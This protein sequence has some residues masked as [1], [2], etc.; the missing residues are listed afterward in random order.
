M[1]RVDKR[2]SI[3]FPNSV[4]IGIRENEYF[5]YVFSQLPCD[6]SKMSIL[7]FKY[8]KDL[9]VAAEELYFIDYNQEHKVI[10]AKDMFNICEKIKETEDIDIYY[11]PVS[12]NF[13]NIDE[14]HKFLK[15]VIND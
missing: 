7:K 9:T 2:D 11:H 4:F 15:E 13:S 10:L 3:Y 8:K 5:L 1:W 12:M 6:N 14:I